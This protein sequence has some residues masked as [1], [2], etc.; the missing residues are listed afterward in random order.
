MATY[1]GFPYIPASHYGPLRSR[2]RLVVVH[3]AE[4]PLQEGIARAVANFF[5]NQPANDP[6]PT[7][8]HAMADDKSLIRMVP[9]ENMAWAAGPHGNVV[10]LHI[11]HA[12]EASFSAAQWSGPYAKEMLVYSA[13]QIA[14]WCVKYHIP[15]VKL[16]SAEVARGYAGICGHVDLS[17][18]YP[19]D[20]SHTDPGADWPWALHLSLI[21]A[22]VARLT[23]PPTHAKPKP[24]AHA[25]AVLHRLHLK[26]KGIVSKII[27]PLRPTVVSLSRLQAAAHHDPAAPGTPKEYASTVL[28]VEKALAAEG[29]LPKQYVDGSYG[30]LTVKAYAGWQ[31]RLGYTGNAADGIPGPASLAALGK[32]RGFVVGK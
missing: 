24:D 23:K 5:H 15:V 8:A 11:E 12:G 22:E 6:N 21:R 28:P 2:T 1:N 3:T 18:A 7:S 27:H 32:R 17:H 19:Q 30:T 14:M 20:T 4:T 13:H 25:L 16:T 9:D 31:H 10:G 26:S 29:L